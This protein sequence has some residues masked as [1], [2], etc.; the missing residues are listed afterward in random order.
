[1]VTVAP[2]AANVRALAP[3]DRRPLLPALSIPTARVD[4]LLN[5]VAPTVSVPTPAAPGATVA[6]P[7]TMSGPVTVPVPPSLW[8]LARANRVP[9]ELAPPVTPV[10]SSVAPAAIE[11]VGLLANEPVPVRASVPAAT[12][13]LPAYVLAA[14]S[15]N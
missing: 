12:I 7:T 9:S 13:V 14:V 4:P 8:L 3:S 10:T 6:P 15:S 11:M 2:E 5:V 1:M